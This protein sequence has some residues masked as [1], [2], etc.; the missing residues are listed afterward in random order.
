M[1]GHVKTKGSTG[2]ADVTNSPVLG[3]SVDKEM[4]PVETITD[5]GIDREEKSIK[6]LRIS[7]TV[8]L[9]LTYVGMASSRF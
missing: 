7:K 9:V 6:W 4:I 8:L 5:K 3:K 1:D 2:L